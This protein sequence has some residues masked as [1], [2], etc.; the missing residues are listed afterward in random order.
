MSLDML[1]DVAT[2]MLGAF[3]DSA[4]GSDVCQTVALPVHSSLF[5]F[6]KAI[7]QKGK[8]VSALD[9]SAS[10]PI[11]R[12]SRLTNRFLFFKAY[13]DNM[14][15]KDFRTIIKDSELYASIRGGKID[16]QVE[17]LF[18]GNVK[19]K[20]R[21]V[22]F[23]TA[24]ELHLDYVQCSAH[25]VEEKKYRRCFA[26]DKIGIMERRLNVTQQ[27]NGLAGGAVECGDVIDKHWYFHTDCFAKAMNILH[28]Y[29]HLWLISK[30]IGNYKHQ[31]YQ[32]FLDGCTPSKQNDNTVVTPC[33]HNFR[34]LVNVDFEEPCMMINY[35]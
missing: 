32:A 21:F 15:N 3:C 25:I 18:G 33:Y 27:S 22:N 6:K 11:P 26:C 30:P 5:Q 7:K 10:T 31:G 16:E 4:T 28:I 12:M 20:G 23:A 35:I 14:C 13:R 29:H 8:N 1:L 24:G 2:D 9:D 17:T 19:N 34:E